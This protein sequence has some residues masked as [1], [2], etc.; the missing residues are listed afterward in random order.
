[1][2]ARLSFSLLTSIRSS[3][4]LRSKG[5]RSAAC[6]S[7]L[8]LV[9]TTACGAA[10]PA[11]AAPT[12]AEAPRFVDART[13]EPVAFEA[14]VDELARARVIYVGERHDQAL[15]HDVQRRIT[16]A[17]LAREPSIALGFEMFQH[18]RQAA[19]DAYVAGELDEA[20]MLEQTE[21]AR[22]W[23]F[24]YAPYRPLVSLG[25]THGLPLLALNAPQEVT[26]AV[27]RGGL[28]A[29]SE[30]QRAALPDLDLDDAAHRET[31]LAALRH[32]PGM[33]EATLERFYTA[34]VIWD[35]TMAD[36]AAAYL[37]RPDARDKL[38]VFAGTMHVR[39][40]AVPERAARRGATPY[41]IVLPVAA[42][43]LEAAL[44]AEPPPADFLLVVPDPAP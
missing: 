41:A 4:P 20:Q 31:V 24:D 25:R 6:R 21:W 16:E 28:E 18:P 43:A 35:E 38:V 11:P 33:D 36:R 39:R 23:G 42:R 27:A 14:M 22:R 13:G 3:G 7:V 32:H 26:R 29:L 19:L 2:R 12:E 40:P 9:L 37:A 15:D 30:T 5:P 10:R 17:L 8:A 44:R 1:M 34:Q